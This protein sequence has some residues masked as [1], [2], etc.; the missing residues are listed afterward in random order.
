MTADL[1]SKFLI[2]NVSLCVIR[3]WFLEISEASGVDN[4][5]S[6]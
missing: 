6:I 1:D 5:D 2:A 4:R 3:T